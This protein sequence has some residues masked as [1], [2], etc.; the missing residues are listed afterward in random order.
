M[1]SK[2]ALFYVLAAVSAGCVPILSL[3]PL[4]TAQT[5]TFDERL[6]GSWVEDANGEEHVAVLTTCPGRPERPSDVLREHNR[7]YR[8]MVQNGPQK[9]IF[10]ACLVKLDDRLSW[11]SSQRAF[12]PGV[13]RGG[14]SRSSST[15]RCFFV[16]APH[17]LQGR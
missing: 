2:K 6:L 12:H 14:A 11:I 3:Q 17:V 13:Q 1:K 9:G 5:L 16:P 7:V 15:T 10:T 8:L 4:Y